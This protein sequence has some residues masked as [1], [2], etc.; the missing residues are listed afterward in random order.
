MKRPNSDPITPTLEPKADASATLAQAGASQ[1]PA[2]NAMP[3]LAAYGAAPA[4]VPE[5]MNRSPGGKFLMFFSEKSKVHARKILAKFP[6]VQDGEPFLP[7]GDTYV[8]VIECAFVLLAEFPHYARSKQNGDN[9]ETIGVR[10]TD[11]GKQSGVA[12]EDK[13]KLQVLTQLLVIPDA[14]GKIDERLAP[15]TLTLTTLRTTKANFGNQLLKGIK[16]AE[17]AEW[18]KE[19]PMHGAMVQ[20]GIPPRFR[21]CGEMRRAPGT[22]KGSGRAFVAVDADVKT[23]SVPQIEQ[24]LNVWF[25]SEAGQAARK[26]TQERYDEEVKNL[27]ALREKTNPDK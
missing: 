25:P 4:A 9:W 3:G 13:Y 26:N 16:R 14:N 18:V 5:A 17:T 15:C 8:P 27:T 6:D 2:F 11:P 1:L 23:L 22:A 20:G 7:L 12:D 10:F 21:V 19:N 24:V